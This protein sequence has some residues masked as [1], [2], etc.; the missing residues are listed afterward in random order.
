VDATN[1]MSSPFGHN[2]TFV[3]GISRAY[4]RA[5]TITPF[6]FLFFT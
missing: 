4:N 6:L 3:F 5:L 1:V 2:K